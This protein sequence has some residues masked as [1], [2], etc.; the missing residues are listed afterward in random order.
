MSR[1]NRRIDRRRQV[2]LYKGILIGIAVCICLVLTIILSDFG[3]VNASGEI[4]RQ[5]QYVTVEVEEGDSI[6]SIAEEYKSDEYNS[7]RD[8]VEEIEVMNG[9]QENTVLKPG[10][11]IMVPN[12]VETAFDS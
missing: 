3:K 12:Y 4:H 6:W 5:K 9:L 10:N 2:A 11:R 8:L 1:R 7:T